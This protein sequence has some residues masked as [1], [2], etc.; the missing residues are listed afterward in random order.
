MMHSPRII[1]TF[2]ALFELGKHAL[3]FVSFH[4]G[5]T[6]VP[7][8][9]VVQVDPLDS[10]TP[11]VIS[12]STG[13]LSRIRSADADPT[14]SGACPVRVGHARY[15]KCGHV[16]V[17]HVAHVWRVERVRQRIDLDRLLGLR[18]GMRL[19]LYRLLRLSGLELR[20]CLVLQY[21]LLRLIIRWRCTRLLTRLRGLKLI[22]LLRLLLA[23]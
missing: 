8:V 7:K 15:P 13:D 6:T 18:F 12:V 19:G 17:A 1:M 22:V 9:K 5:H 4:I 20:M 16:N 11:V 14:H 3:E 23:L 2:W 10:V 21:R